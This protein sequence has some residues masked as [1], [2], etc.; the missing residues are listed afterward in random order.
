[1]KVSKTE[2]RFSTTENRF[3][4]NPVLTSLIHY[5]LFLSISACNRI[6]MIYRRILLVSLFLSLLS[7]LTT[8]RS[9]VAD[10][11]DTCR[12]L[13]KKFKEVREKRMRHC[14][15]NCVGLRGS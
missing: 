11:C 2:N 10:K 15:W 13:V 9:E 4:K 7:S 1:M 3:S 14:L 5:I 8:S 12:E 6:Q